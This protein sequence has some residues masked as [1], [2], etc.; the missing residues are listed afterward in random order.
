MER[1]ILSKILDKVKKV[2]ESLGV[3]NTK[4]GTLGNGKA[5][6]LK[7]FSTTGAYTL[8]LTEDAPYSA[9]YLV[10]ASAGTSGVTT[11]A[12]VCNYNNAWVI[13]GT[14]EAGVTISEGVLTIPQYRRWMIVY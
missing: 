9:N 10:I 2:R 1:D 14:N 13:Q 3:L 5:N 7:G 6:I 8:E 12:H 11:I 4:V